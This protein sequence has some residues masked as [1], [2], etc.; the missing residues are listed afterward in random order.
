MAGS[1]LN[2]VFRCMYH[3]KIRKKPTYEVLLVEK[4][5]KPRTIR[6]ATTRAEAVGYCREF[7]KTYGVSLKKKRQ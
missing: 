7:E 2:G 4:G 5:K 6:L 1:R 3:F